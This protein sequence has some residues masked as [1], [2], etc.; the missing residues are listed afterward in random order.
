VTGLDLVVLVL[1][2]QRLTSLW[3]EE[4]TSPIRFWLS[5]KAG[6]V[7]Y[8]AGCR[9]CISLWAAAV[10]YGLWYVPYAFILIGILALSGGSL[11][12]ETFMLIRNGWNR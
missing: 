5:S 2:T 6:K 7:G 4:I 11:V 10:I 3:F 9:L 1:A 8:L 12:L